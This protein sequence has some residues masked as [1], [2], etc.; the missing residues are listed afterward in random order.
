[1]VEDNLWY[2]QSHV[3]YGSIEKYKYRF[4]THG[5]SQK[6]GI[7]Y[8]ET[9]APMAR[10]TSIRAI[11]AL[12]T[13]LGW[14]LHQMDMKT[15]FLNGVVKDKV[16]VEQPLGFETHDRQ[17]HVCKWEKALYRLKQV[18]RT[19][20]GRIDSFLMSL[21][22][23]K[24]KVVSNHCDKIDDDYDDPIHHVLMD[25]WGSWLLGRKFM[26]GCVM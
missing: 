2:D 3:E 19:W 16:Y 4:V 25:T 26:I 12:A 17:S 23:T 11:M 14:K 1:M 6:E 13:K 18:P 7:D 20:Y 9:F 15:T 21:D 10:C 8:E 22:F 24:S 5:F